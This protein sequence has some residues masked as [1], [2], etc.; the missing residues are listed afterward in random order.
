MSPATW[1]L[2]IMSISTSTIVTLSSN[3]WLLA[4]IGLEL[5]TLSIL[6][7]II[8]SN[9][10]RATEAATKYFLTQAAAAALIMFS[11]I[12]NAWKTGQW[13]IINML[14]I[15]TSIATLAIL[16]KLGLAPMHFW[17]PEVL[18]G[19]TMNTAMIISTWQKIAPL[20]LLYLTMMNSPPEV[21]LTVG[22]T[23]T[24]I[25]GLAGMN[26]T[27]TRK[28]M[29]FSSIGHMGWMI[30]MIPFNL[31]LVT[32]SLIMYMTLTIPMFFM[33]NTTTAITLKDF[34]QSYIYTPTLTVTMMIILMSLGGLPPL[35]GFMPKLLILNMLTNFKLMLLASLMAL[36]SLP[37]L[38]F[39]L[40][41]TYITMLTSPPKTTN[42]QYKWRLKPNYQMNI[43]PLV[44]NS[45]MLLPM[46]PLLLYY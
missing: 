19:S 35:S 10:P 13:M 42:T 6:P 16:L 34:S 15:P 37:T 2:M 22:L 39:Y 17:Y 31:S 46:T 7:I 14:P 29:A 38:F 40:R 41:M 45:T 27:Q 25:A 30:T 43:T 12:L 8:K 1:A 24:L 44:L 4:W 11:S 3:H 28:I 36:T 23:S 18:Q 26:Q 33:L 32:L 9:H 20:S 21:L 5:N